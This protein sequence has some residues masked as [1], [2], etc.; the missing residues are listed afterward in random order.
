MSIPKFLLTLSCLLVICLFSSKALAQSE[1]DLQEMYSKVLDKR[2]WSPVVDA[3]GDVQFEAEDRTYFIEV[4]EDDLDYFRLV[5]P[6]IWPIESFKE[7]L[8]VLIAC[9]E[10]NSTVKVARAYTVQDNV[11]V[12]VDIF[13][14]RPKDFEDVLDRCMESIDLAVNTFVDAMR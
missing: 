14:R 11:W 1:E 2:G 8:D 7:G 5:L 4:N 6:N 12:E 10:V 3:D 13:V 9:D